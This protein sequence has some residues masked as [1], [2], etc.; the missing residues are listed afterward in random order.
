VRDGIYETFIFHTNIK[1]DIKVT[2]GRPTM[3]PAIK[4]EAQ[5]STNLTIWTEKDPLICFVL[6][7]DNTKDLVVELDRDSGIDGSCF[8]SKVNVGQDWIS[9]R[10]KISNRKK[11][12]AKR[13]RSNEKEKDEG[14]K[15]EDSLSFFKNDILS[16]GKLNGFIINI[17]ARKECVELNPKK[18]QKVKR[19]RNEQGSDDIYF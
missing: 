5:L 16:E 18:K 4:G 17:D 19:S 10:L 11:A 13:R 8:S 2:E 3:V 12:L 7:G 15:N 1:G 14:D 9:I 6:I